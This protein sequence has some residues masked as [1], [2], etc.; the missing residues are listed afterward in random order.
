MDKT[1]PKDK[2]LTIRTNDEELMI[3]EARAYLAGVSRSD[4]VRG[5]IEKSWGNRLAK[6]HRPYVAIAGVLL[7]VSNKLLKIASHEKLS[8]IE[9]KQLLKTSQKLDIVLDQ[10]T[11]RMALDQEASLS[12]DNEE[13]AF[14]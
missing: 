2:Y 7:D 9:K 3:I 14:E 5:M 13:E 8:E 11:E 1:T 6:A 12:A 10:I 4:F